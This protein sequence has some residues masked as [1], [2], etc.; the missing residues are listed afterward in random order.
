MITLNEDSLP[1]SI[2]G[3]LRAGSWKEL[4]KEKQ[5]VKKKK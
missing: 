4:M 2:V 5:A 3:T 1:W